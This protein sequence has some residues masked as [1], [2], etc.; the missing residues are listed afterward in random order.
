MTSTPDVT[1]ELGFNAAMREHEILAEVLRLDIDPTTLIPKNARQ[2]LLAEVVRKAIDT[3]P[4]AAPAMLKML[5]N[6]ILTFDDCDEGFNEME[7]YIPFRIPNC[8]YW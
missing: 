6:Y 5:T 1:E 3:D 4:D 8:G 2:K 7:K